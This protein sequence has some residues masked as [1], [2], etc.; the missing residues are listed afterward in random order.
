MR[1]FRAH[2]PIV[3][4]LVL[5]LLLA[6][7]RV[8]SRESRV[9]DDNQYDNDNERLT[10]WVATQP[11]YGQIQELRL[12]RRFMRVFHQRNEFRS[13]I[14]C[15]HRTEPAPPDGLRLPFDFAGAAQARCRWSTAGV[16]WGDARD[17]VPARRGAGA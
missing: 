13:T 7:E 6:L 12:V 14:L 11:T 2:H 9:D 15:D 5:V 4:V 16:K 17:A 8:A 10:F 3:L 1:A